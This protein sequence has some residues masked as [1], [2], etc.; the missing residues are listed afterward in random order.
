MNSDGTNVIQLTAN[1]E[2]DLWP[3]WSPDGTRIVYVSYVDDDSG[4]I[5]TMKTDGKDKVRLTNNSAYEETPVY[6]P[7]G[8]RLAYSVWSPATDTS[9]IWVINTNGTSPFNLTNATGS[10]NAYPAWS[11]DGRMIAFISDRLTRGVVS[12][13]QTDIFVINL[14]SYHLS[15]ITFSTDSSE[16]AP[17]WKP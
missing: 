1:S 10:E 11:P 2:D 16:T 17:D 6:A 8:T 14:T 9:N 5:Y 15:Q 12:P 13:P 4:E 7:D 3:S